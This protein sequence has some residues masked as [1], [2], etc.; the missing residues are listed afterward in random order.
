MKGTIHSMHTSLKLRP[1][2]SCSKL[3][4]LDVTQD[5]IELVADM[6]ALLRVKGALLMASTEPWAS[7]IIVCCSCF[8]S[9]LL[10]RRKVGYWAGLECSFLMICLAP[11]AAVSSRIASV[12]PN[13]TGCTRMARFC[14]VISISFIWCIA[15][16]N[17]SREF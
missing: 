9:S 1:L 12:L 11:E 17:I 13:F 4:G 14:R 10:Y 7:E 16:R 6:C 2:V 3:Q 15:N 8:M 5:P